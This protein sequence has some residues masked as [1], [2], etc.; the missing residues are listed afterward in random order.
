MID[1]TSPYLKSLLINKGTKHGIVKG[2]TIFSKDYLIG[3]VVE[4]NYL[5]SRV[6][7]ITDLN[8][9]IPAIIQDTDVNVILS[10]NG[11]KNNFLLEFL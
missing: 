6:L 9:K 1:Q 8:S 10:G 7:L 4:V 5:S 11:N 2:M 3:T